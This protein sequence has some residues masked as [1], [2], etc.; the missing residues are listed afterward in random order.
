MGDALAF[1]GI[2]DPFTDVG[3]DTEYQYIGDVHDFSLK[4]SY[5][6]ERQ[7]LEGEFGAG[8]SSNLTDFLN[9]FDISANYV[10]NHTIS[11]TG[12]YFNTWGTRDVL[13]NSGFTTGS[14]NSSGWIFDLAYL[15]FSYGG[16]AIWPWLNAR[17]GILYTHYNR[18]DGSV[19][20]VDFTPGR[21]AQ[22][23]DTTFVYTWVAF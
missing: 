1:P 12:A 15:P 5:I 6:W 10:Y 8:A 9:N 11:L 3:V 19:N 13:F 20:N 22:D 14:P 7:K 4:A 16:P 21:T 23:N 2:T 18:F 17:I